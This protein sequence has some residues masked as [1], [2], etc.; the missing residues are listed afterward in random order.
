MLLNQQE[1]INLSPSASNLAAMVEL[2]TLVDVCP[3]TDANIHFKPSQNSGATSS[4]EHSSSVEALR[5][6]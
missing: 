5:T 4:S 2:K 3:Y 6:S 1:N